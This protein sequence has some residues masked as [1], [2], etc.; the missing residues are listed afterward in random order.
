MAAQER[1]LTGPRAPPYTIQVVT[2]EQAAVSQPVD[3][4]PRQVKAML[5]AVHHV[6]WT[7]EKQ[8]NTPA[9]AGAH[10]IT[11]VSQVAALNCVLD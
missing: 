7:C 8:C 4:C 3:I 9:G 6:P 5:L 1:T 11:K 10:G 2:T